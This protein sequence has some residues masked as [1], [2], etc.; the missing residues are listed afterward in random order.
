MIK[1]LKFLN[2]NNIKKPG[3]LSVSPKIYDKFIKK[4]IGI[5][6]NT[7]NKIKNFKAI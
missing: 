3:Y 4:L 2:K 6:K 5:S 1:N 7:T